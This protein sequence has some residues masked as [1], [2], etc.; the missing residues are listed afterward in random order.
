MTN[1]VHRKHT[2]HMCLRYVLTSDSETQIP[3]NTQRYKLF[4][5]GTAHH[6]IRIPVK[7]QYTQVPLFSKSE[8][9]R[10]GKFSAIYRSEPTLR[11]VGR[12][13]TVSGIK[14]TAKDASSFE[15]K[16]LKPPWAPFIDRELNDTVHVTWTKG[17]DYSYINGWSLKERDCLKTPPCWGL[18][19]PIMNPIKHFN[20]K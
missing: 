7:G 6:R 4:Q 8:S 11:R 17:T 12:L 5:W 1:V 2:W 9:L 20:G 14:S 18:I 13:K 15:N 19:L 3:P 10:E 16:W